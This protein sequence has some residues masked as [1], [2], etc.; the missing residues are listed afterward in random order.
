[1]SVIYY[2]LLA[3]LFVTPYL[4]APYWRFMP[5][6]GLMLLLTWCYKKN[7]FLLFFGLK[8][9]NIKEVLISLSLLAS[10][11]LASY[12]LI[13]QIINPLGYQNLSAWPPIERIFITP[14]HVLMEE[15]VFRAI[16][17]GLLI[18]K[19]PKPFAIT[20]KVAVLFSYA[21]WLMYGPIKNEAY[22]NLYAL[23]TLFNIGLA[24]NLI[25]LKTRSILIPVAIHLGWNYFRFGIKWLTPFGEPLSEGQSFN[26]IEGHPYVLAISIL[27]L[28]TSIYLF[29]A[30][31]KD[32]IFNSPRALRG[33]R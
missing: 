2:V 1:M 5:F 33:E 15:I 17:L 29:A 10:A 23:V 13:P 6:L 28:L 19:W 25:Y 7:E 16:L 20:I 32:Q 11:L 4:L 31:K 24:L 21:H 3:P 12:L 8:K 22:L 9:P 27:I 14:F 18:K 26:L 30:N